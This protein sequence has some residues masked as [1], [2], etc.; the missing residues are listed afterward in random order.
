MTRKIGSAYKNVFERGYAKN[1]ANPYLED[2]AVSTWT[3]IPTDGK[4]RKQ[5]KEGA[6]KAV[7]DGGIKNIRSK[8]TSTSSGSVA[9]TKKG[10]KLWV[11]EYAKLGEQDKNKKKRKA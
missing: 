10:N 3:S 5:I 6:N 9:T 1:I 11:Q 4:M 2:G 7:K 8:S